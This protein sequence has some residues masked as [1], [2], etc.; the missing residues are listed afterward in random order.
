MQSI[1]LYTP[2]PVRYGA[3]DPDQTNWFYQSLKNTA[4]LATIYGFFKREDLN[5]GLQRLWPRGRR[6]FDRRTADILQDEKTSDSVKVLTAQKRDGWGIRPF[7]QPDISVPER[8]SMFRDQ[9]SASPIKYL[10]YFPVK[11]SLLS[12]RRFTGLSIPSPG[13]WPVW[14]R[15][16]FNKGTGFIQW[17]KGADISGNANSMLS[18]NLADLSGSS[19]PGLNASHTQMHHVNAND[20]NWPGGNFTATDFVKPGFFNTWLAGALFRHTTG[21]PSADPQNWDPRMQRITWEGKSPN[22]PMAMTFQDFAKKQ[23]EYN[24]FQHVD[25]FKSLFKGSNLTGTQFKAFVRMLGLDLRGSIL[26]KL[27]APRQDWSGVKVAGSNMAS[28]QTPHSDLKAIDGLQDANMDSPPEVPGNYEGCDLRGQNLANKKMRFN[29]FRFAVFSPV[30]PAG[31][32]SRRFYRCQPQNMGSY[33]DKLMLTPRQGKLSRDTLAKTVKDPTSVIGKKLFN[34]AYMD[35]PLETRQLVDA[36]TDEARLALVK[37]ALDKQAFYDT[38]RQS[39]VTEQRQW[40][41]LWKNI[42]ALNAKKNANTE[43]ADFSGG[44]VSY[45]NFKGNNL[46][47]SRFVA[48]N[49]KHTLLADSDV[50]KT[51]FTNAKNLPYSQLLQ[52]KN[53]DTLLV[54]KTNLQSLVNLIQQGASISIIKNKFNETFIDKYLSKKDRVNQIAY[55]LAQNNILKQ[56][57][58]RLLRTWRNLLGQNWAKYAKIIPLQSRGDKS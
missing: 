21:L 46:T 14:W 26:N 43:K 36:N 3:T 29:N 20:A 6:E 44:D 58:S 4:P 45:A 50:K 32:S 23:M 41:T 11:P 31:V 27:L 28:V 38:L 19:L 7:P 47:K 16:W 13:A 24:V 2:A 9:P 39:K 22:D 54:E 12:G 10:P 30:S 15:P 35:R 53:M 17:R 55:I 56:P 40:L 25:L 18:H 51:N 33:L 34:L 48:T 49:M 1:T 57:D 8:E 5:H 37:L 52:A 42:K